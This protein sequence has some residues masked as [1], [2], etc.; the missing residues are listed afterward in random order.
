MVVHYIE[1]A[2]HCC[3]FR[4]LST[5]TKPNLSTIRMVFAVVELST[6]DDAHFGLS[7]GLLPDIVIG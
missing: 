3:W 4:V 2:G 5:G 1:G 6:N 7:L